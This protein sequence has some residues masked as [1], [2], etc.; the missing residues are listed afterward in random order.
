[1]KLALLPAVVLSIASLGTG[2]SL[3]SVRPSKPDL[4]LRE[5]LDPVIGFLEC[6]NGDA[7]VQALCSVVSHRVSAAL[8]AA[9]V[10]VDRTGILFAYDDP[11]DRKID[12]GHSCTVTASVQHTH[13]EAKLLAD[14][15]LDF[16]GNPLAVSDPALFV[17]E[18]PV[19]LA[20][21][22]DVKQR[23]G[24]RV[25]GSCVG[26]GS[27]SFVVA[28]GVQTR[29]RVAV[30]FT[31]APALVR[32]DAAGDYVFTIRPIVKV[33]A[34]LENTDIDF[35]ISGVSFLSGL[36]TAVLGGTSSVFKA[37]THLLKGDSLGSVWDDI[38]RSVIDGAVGGVLSIPFDLLDNVVEL[39]AQ[40]Y[41]DEKQGSVAQE[42][43][44]EMEKRLRA[45][46][47]NALGLDAN[48]ERS[49]VIRKEVVDLVSRFGVG[50]DVFLPDKRPG[51]CSGDGD[52]S[53]GVFCNG[54]ERC[55]NE[56][57]VKGE[58]PCFGV[59]LRCVESSRRCVSTCG[60]RTGR[61]CP[62]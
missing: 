48:G 47:S 58:P 9:H 26:L 34:Q 21:R 61:I 39:L 50:A 28:G 6:T 3:I 37:V 2:Q 51:Y 59:D 12:T 41:V 55:V 33:A 54:A 25:L 4:R 32:T 14:A 1:M 19:E 43:S 27:D 24:S 16:S 11:A 30:L 8:A 44:G 40:A 23:F 22:I 18:L 35:N 38:K 57:C 53:D 56:Q 29:A 46:V 45:L 60:G 49:F 5:I 52:C 15:S 10:R 20:A 7:T 62:K 17:A 42:Y 31:F 36:L 13:A